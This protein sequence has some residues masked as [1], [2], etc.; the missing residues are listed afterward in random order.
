MNELEQLAGSGYILQ[1]GCGFEVAVE[2]EA[3][4]LG[5]VKIE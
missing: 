2:V 5:V 4:E 3:I 1:A